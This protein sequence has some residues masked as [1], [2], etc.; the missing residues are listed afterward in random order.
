[1]HMYYVKVVPTTFEPASGEKTSTNQYSVTEHMKKLDPTADSVVAKVGKQAAQK[2]KKKGE[3][4]KPS[5]YFFYEL[6][7]IMVR[8]T[9]RRKPFLHFITQLCAILGGIFTVAG[10]VDRF[11]YASLQHVQKKIELG[12]FS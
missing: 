7:P 5:V 4:L 1:M 3:N 2:K 8:V 11:V 10:L 12:K 9:E 6:S